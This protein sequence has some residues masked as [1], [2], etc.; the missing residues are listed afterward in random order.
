MNILRNA[1]KVTK[2]GG[3]VLG[4]D[5]MGRRGMMRPAGMKGWL[6]PP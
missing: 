5:S 4:R 2:A 1:T 6:P 3:A